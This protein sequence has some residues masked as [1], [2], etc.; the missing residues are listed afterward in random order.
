[1]SR[2]QDG[3][4]P[5][6]GNSHTFGAS[7]AALRPKSQL[8]GSARKTRATTSMDKAVSQPA[9]IGALPRV[10]QPSL[11]LRPPMI[12]ALPKIPQVC[13]GKHADPDRQLVACW[14][15]LEGNQPGN[16]PL[17]WSIVQTGM[18]NKDP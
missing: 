13:W 3:Q 17:H 15:A 14:M 9:E 6:G 8:A 7:D 18:D 1:M 2:H 10:R 16:N 5:C 11:D 4:T 12:W